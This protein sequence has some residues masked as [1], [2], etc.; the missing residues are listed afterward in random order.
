MK[1]TYE[2]EYDNWTECFTEP[3][4]KAANVEPQEFRVI[5][6]DERRTYLK[7]KIWNAEAAPT[8]I[9]M[10]KGA[11]EEHTWVIKRELEEIDATRAKM[12]Y[13]LFDWTSHK[14]YESEVSKG[15]QIIHMVPQFI[16]Q[17][18]FGLVHHGDKGIEAHHVKY[19][20]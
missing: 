4:L 11:W 1:I 6:A 20:S 16:S 3:I 13:I 5:S 19:I 9:G 7:V 8:I 10:A 18:E 17:G 15:C 12:H 14:T 2:C